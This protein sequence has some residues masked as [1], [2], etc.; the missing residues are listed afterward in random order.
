MKLRGI[1]LVALLLAPLLPLAASA[2]PSPTAWSPFTASSDVVDIAIAGSG[3]AVAAA[4]AAPV[5]TPTGTGNVATSAPADLAIFDSQTGFAYNG[6]GNSGAPPPA[7]AADTKDVAQG[8]LFTAVSR[9]GSSIAS[10]GL[11]GVPTGPGVGPVPAPTTTTTK[12]YY[13]RISPGTTW[14][15]STSATNVSL[16]T[17]GTPTNLIISPDG[18]RVAGVFNEQGKFVLRAWSFS[19]STLNQA[20]TFE[21]SGKANDLAATFDFQHLVVAAEIVELNE[22]HG[23]LYHFTFDGTRPETL[24]ERSFNGSTLVSAGIT[25]DL[26]LVAGDGRGR[27]LYADRTTS[28]TPVEVPGAVGNVTLK[29]S[30]DG[31][32]VVTAMTGGSLAVF[33]TRSTP[34][35]IW[36]ASAGG[37]VIDIS[38]NKT[39][40][41]FAVAVNGTGAVAY[42]DNS[43]APLWKFNGVSRAVAMNE[44]GTLVAYGLRTTVSVATIARTMAFEFAGG[45]KVAPAKPV[46]P[47][48][49]ATFDVNLRNSGAGLERVRFQIAQNLDVVVVADSP[50]VAIEPG[51]TRVVTFSATVGSTFSGTRSFNISAVAISSGAVDNVTVTLQPQTTT[52]VSLVLNGTSE[53]RVLA[54]Q[55][56][57]VVIGVVNNGT[58]DAALGIRATQTPSVGGPWNVTLDPPSFT[59]APNT[60]TTVRVSV[61]P[62]ADAVNGTADTVVLTLEG[63]EVSDSAQ[64]IFRINPTLNVAIDAN[65]RVKFVEPG[66]AAFYNVTVT[67]AGSL[68]RQFEAF[69]Q[70]TPTGG[71]SWAV[72]MDTSRFL[73]T[74]G[75][76]KTIPV[77]IFAPAD[78]TPSDR[79]SVFVTA[80]SITELANETVVQA[81]LTLYANAVAPQPTSTTPAG[82]GIPG[83]ELVVMLGAVVALSVVLRGRRSS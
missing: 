68:P 76:S 11:V 38:L 13:Q 6:S 61:T 1:V 60:I 14:L 53:V 74:P 15:P 25:P 43:S 79:V 9:D 2:P 62:P 72:D 35:L 4:L 83:V 70:A 54:G 46:K 44:E 48:G 17:T 10:V 21:Q 73:L 23:A 18:T 27:L 20:L 64:I 42:G 28:F 49:T 29:V 69:F 39:G 12:L 33:D 16:Y 47:L 26:R 24:Y 75:A 34:S 63:P 30:Q 65:G 41:M 37:E 50:I 78:A 5:Q 22:T 40:A 80:R 58:R 7:P 3:R 67:N 8:R 57:D 31:S 55:R 36:N 66:K 32:R 45:S 19:G 59:L 77:K 81:N 51:A 52:A 71:K 82:N 56:T